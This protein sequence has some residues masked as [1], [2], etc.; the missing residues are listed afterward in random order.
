MFRFLIIITLILNINISFS[1]EKEIDTLFYNL[2][3]AED[4]LAAQNFEKK[5]LEYLD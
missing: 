5:N 3:S 2:Q 1:Q 4:N